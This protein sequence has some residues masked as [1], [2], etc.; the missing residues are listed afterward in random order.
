MISNL[1]KGITL[2]AGIAIGTF[3]VQL[4]PLLLVGGGI[5]LL[6]K[7]APKEAEECE[8]GQQEKSNS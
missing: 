1:T 3:L 2:G 6:Y 7:F 8:S 4:V 5:Y